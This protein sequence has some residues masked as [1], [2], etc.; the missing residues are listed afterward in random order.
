MCVSLAEDSV[1]LGLCHRDARGIDH[2][3]EE[4]S[5]VYVEFAFFS[6]GVKLMFLK[7]SKN[8][9]N[10]FIVFLRSLGVNEDIVQ[11]D[12]HV[13]V[14]DVGEDAVH[15]TLESSGSVGE[16]KVH[17]HKIK[18]SITSSEG[19]FPFITGSDADEVVGTMEVDLG[20]DGGGAEAIE[21]VGNEQK[22]I[23]VFLGDGIKTTPIDT[24]MERA[25]LLFDEKNG[26]AT[27]G[28]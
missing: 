14:E 15:I 27:G 18:G 9:G 19:G 21:E 10:M 22:R 25:V 7:A 26:C 5:S 23:L 11:I 24:K 16:A 20:R 28:L 12:Y 3:A 13:F 8:F 2:K 4:F 6:F 1:N 17:D